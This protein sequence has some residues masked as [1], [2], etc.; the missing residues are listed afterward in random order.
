MNRNWFKQKKDILVP[1]MLTVIGLLAIGFVFLSIVKPQALLQAS[2][3]QLIYVYFLVASVPLIALLPLLWYLIF[4]RKAKLQ[5]IFLIAAILMGVP[6]TLAN[7]PN[8][9]YDE[10]TH[11][12]NAMFYADTIFSGA[13]SSSDSTHLIWDRRVDDT[14]NGTTAHNVTMRDYEYTAAHFFDLAQDPEARETQ[15]VSRLNYPYQYLPQILGIEIGHLL[16]LGQIPTFYL[17]RLLNFVL[18]LTAMYFI[19]KKAP[20]KTLFCLMGL[21]PFVLGTAFSCSYDNPINILVFAFCAYVLHLAA[22]KTSITK[23]DILILTVLF[24]LF[25]PLKYIYSPLILLL[26]LIP[27]NRFKSRQD[28]AMTIGLPIF[29]GL[30][31][32]L[33]G[34]GSLFNAALSTGGISAFNEQRQLDTYTYGFIFQQ[35]GAAA[36]II[37]TTAFDNLSEVLNGPRYLYVMKGDLPIW[38]SLM[39]IIMLLVAANDTTGKHCLHVSTQQKL[40]ILIICAVI[41]FLSVVALL[42]HTEVGAY[43]VQGI[44]GR[45]YIPLLPLVALLGQ[46]FLQPTS[47]GSG[48]LIF[49]MVAL[50]FYTILFLFQH[51][52]VA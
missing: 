3:P 9:W 2:Q 29:A 46:G 10:P 28:R 16:N 23:R 19:I 22:V 24:A 39:I 1:I 26:L 11:Y 34:S 47:R 13:T 45:Y 41:Y 6:Q 32:M 37:L 20:F 17:A 25:A 51:A 42:T 30:L 48:T 35:P 8:S 4:V 27:K 49:V 21:M 50:N 40:I 5:N 15:A 18:F 52:L 7:T 12:Y 14:L 36:R 33:L 31:L 38:T 44:Q 43:M